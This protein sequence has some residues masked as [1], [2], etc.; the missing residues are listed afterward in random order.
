MSVQ[1]SWLVCLAN[2]HYS[3]DLLPQAVIAM[4]NLFLRVSK[5]VAN[6]VAR[7][8]FVRLLV[9]SNAHGPVMLSYSVRRQFNCY[10]FSR[11]L[12]KVLN[13]HITCRLLE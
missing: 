3:E 9:L 6:A 1:L 12:S 10:N 2:L 8:L 5:R 11:T 4:L 13:C 7:I